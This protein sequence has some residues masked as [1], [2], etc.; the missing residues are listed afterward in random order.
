MS[1][2]RS[3]EAGHRVP[4]RH[5]SLEEQL[6]LVS[7]IAQAA[8]HGSR[9]AAEA[10]ALDP[11]A[12]ESVRAVLHDRAASKTWQLKAQAA[13]WLARDLRQAAA[14]VHEAAQAP[15]AWRGHKNQEPF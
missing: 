7:E 5:R 6:G 8:Y 15:N 2:S 3:P 12:A 14:A 10:G 13:A 11:A 9:A 4:V 1:R